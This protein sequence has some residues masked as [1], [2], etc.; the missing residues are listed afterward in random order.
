MIAKHA[1]DMFAEILRLR[2]QRPLAAWARDH[3]VV[4]YQERPGAFLTGDLLAQLVKPHALQSLAVRAGDA[5]TGDGNTGGSCWLHGLHEDTPR[6]PREVTAPPSYV[7]RIGC[8]WQGGSCEP[9]P[10]LAR[11]RTAH[12]PQGG[13]RKTTGYVRRKMSIKSLAC[14]RPAC[15]LAPFFLGKS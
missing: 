11:R 13:F 9:G 12:G 3:D 15:A 7:G 1:N 5:W 6:L 10:S 2:S 4:A 8:A 14:G